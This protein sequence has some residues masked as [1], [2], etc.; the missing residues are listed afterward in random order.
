L[1][2]RI[3]TCPVLR[4]VA[5]LLDEWL[6]DREVEARA[7]GLPRPRSCTIRVIGQAALLEAGLPLRL[8][9]TRDVDV[10]ADYDDAVRR[11][12]AALL[13]AEG[14]EL[15]PVAHEAWMP[16]ETRYSEIF[17]GKFVRLLLAD[18]D[19]ILISKAKM[20]PAK[21][22]QLLTEYLALG[23]SDRFFELAQKYDVDLEKFS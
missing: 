1:Y 23:P 8:A 18:A 19:A 14:R 17:R 2:I 16:K 11:R 9:A 15:D 7:D 10:R 21:N 5:R 12:F 4:D 6:I 20:A 22:R 3:Y 13:A